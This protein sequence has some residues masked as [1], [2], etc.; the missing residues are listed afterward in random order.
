M[1]H[2][3]I[4]ENCA[5]NILAAYP[6][7]SAEYAELARAAAKMVASAVVAAAKG[8]DLGRP[9]GPAHAYAAA[10][11]VVS[12]P[13]TKMRGALVGTYDA[14]IAER[15]AAEEAATPMVGSRVVTIPLAGRSSQWGEWH[16]APASRLSNARYGIVTGVELVQRRSVRVPKTV[17]IL[18]ANGNWAG[19]T[20]TIAATWI[21]YVI[22]EQTWA[23]CQAGDWPDEPYGPPRPPC[24]CGLCPF[25]LM[26]G[27]A[28]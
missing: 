11:P 9:Q 24:Q 27:L 13:P 16:P 5:H 2:T 17:S 23:R 18:M 22:D 21:R 15:D 28:E 25:C 4:I 26:D 14:V 20:T 6:K 12:G 1:D 8:A 7:L 3:T 10:R 19:E